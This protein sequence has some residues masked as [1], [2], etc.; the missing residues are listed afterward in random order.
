MSERGLSTAALAEKI[1]KPQSHISACWSGGR[2]IGEKTIKN[3]CNVLGIKKD[4][5][6]KVEV[7][8]TDPPER[9]PNPIPVISWVQAGSL[10]EVVDVHA[11]GFSGEGEPVY[12]RKHAGPN[13]FA[14]RVEGDSMT[15]RYLP[16]D[17]IVVDPSISCEN[18]CPCV[19]VVNGE[20]TFKFYRETDD[21]IILVPMNDKYPE[22]T[23]KKDSAVDFRVVG[24][25]VD[26]I[27]KI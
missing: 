18:G 7:L 12:S 6:F 20:A 2:N 11:V 3:I 16:G 1:G 19:V 15:P 10:R 27:P 23:I 8:G 21:A 9:Y 14:L 5:F 13:A 25:V 24:K 26:L 4:E 22:T 17:F